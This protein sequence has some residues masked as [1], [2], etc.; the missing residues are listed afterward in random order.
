[1][2][3]LKELIDPE[4]KR[5]KLGLN[6]ST[7]LCVK[8]NSNEFSF[9]QLSFPKIFYKNK[10]FFSAQSLFIGKLKNFGTKNNYQKS[11]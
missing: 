5:L 9:L 2:G 4:E 6:I 10:K 7:S 11:H 8:L 3:Y 1:M